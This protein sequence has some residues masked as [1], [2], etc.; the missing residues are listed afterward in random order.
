MEIDFLNTI[1]VE[2]TKRVKFNYIKIKSICSFKT[3][4]GRDLSTPKYQCGSILHFPASFG[5]E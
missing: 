4:C 1:E 3:P 2:T 5:A